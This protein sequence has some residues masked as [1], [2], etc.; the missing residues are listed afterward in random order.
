[1]RDTNSIVRLPILVLGYN[2]PG[3]LARQLQS[4]ASLHAERVWLS[5]DGPVD[6][7]AAIARSDEVLDVAR[8]FEFPEYHVRVAE[9]NLGCGRAVAGG[10]D[11][12]FGSV[13]A[14]VILEDDCLVHPSFHSF[15]HEMIERYR[16]ESAVGMVSAFNP[17]PWVG[18]SSWTFG[19]PFIWG[20]ATWADRW[21][22]HSLQIG[23]DDRTARRTA[24]RNLGPFWPGLSRGFAAVSRGEVDTWDYQWTYALA[25]RGMV[26]AIPRVNM[27]NNV[28]IGASATHTSD[29]DVAMPPPQSLEDRRLPMS[30]RFDRS[31]AKKAA[32]A[33]RLDRRHQVNQYVRAA[34]RRAARLARSLRVR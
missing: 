4:L 1:M 32:R 12:F 21:R 15:A 30:V 34:G 28:G 7:S 10:I 25:A 5:L 27:V 3:H 31:H 23:W 13:E 19:A 26:S 14:G 17:A 29:L 18:G 16:N 11:W 22:H 33:A 20:W 24:R 9:T 8:S 2:R 6:Q